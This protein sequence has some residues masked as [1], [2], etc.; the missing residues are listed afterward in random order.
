M[1]IQV[2]KYTCLNMHKRVHTKTRFIQAHK[3][4]VSETTHTRTHFANK[5]ARI[6]GFPVRALS[7]E[8]GLPTADL[9]ASPCLSSRLPYGIAVTPAR[10][11]QVERAESAV[12]ALGVT[13]DMRV[14]YHDDLAR[15][16]L[17]AQELAQWLEPAA[18]SRLARAVRAAGFARVAIDLRGFRSGSLNVL[19]GVVAP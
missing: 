4:F 6:N 12:R 1:C 10:L 17:C 14:R 8:L 2:H 16:E 5:Y 9:P 19:E 13:G 18:A 7:R 3:R 15:V 11:A